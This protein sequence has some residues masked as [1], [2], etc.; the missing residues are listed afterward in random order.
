MS[1]NDNSKGIRLEKERFNIEVKYSDEAIEKKLVKFVIKEGNEIVLSADEIISILVNQVNSEILSAA[2]VESQRVNVVEVVRQIQCILDRDYK[3]GE[4]INIGYQHPYPLEFALIEEVWKIAQIKKEVPVVVLTDEMIEKVRLQIKPQQVEFLRKFYKQFKN[5]NTNKNM[6]ET[7]NVATPGDTPVEAVATPN[8]VISESE[9]NAAEAQAV[10]REE[11][12]ETL[13]EEAVEK[14]ESEAT[15][16]EVVADESVA[17][18]P[19]EDAAAT[20]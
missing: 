10:S 17:E 6:E 5:I 8:E 1:N 3:K 13:G 18:T 7:K 14:A 2:F 16:V 4:V 12:V 11:A 20:E 15:P 19:A 9:A